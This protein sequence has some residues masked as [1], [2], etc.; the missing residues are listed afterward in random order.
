MNTIKI[1]CPA[2][3]NLDLRVFPNGAFKVLDR[4]E[5]NYHK[6]LMGYSED[7]DKIIK[8][9]LTYLINMAKENK[10]PFN[11]AKIDYYYNLYLMY[12]KK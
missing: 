12:K 7:I 11:G 9:E 2:K 10:E 8:H 1:K 5:Y 6:K 3:I 4:G